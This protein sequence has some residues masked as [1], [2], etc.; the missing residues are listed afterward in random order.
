MKEIVVGVDGSAQST[1][2]LRW[3]AELAARSG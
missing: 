3:A 1:T 2:A